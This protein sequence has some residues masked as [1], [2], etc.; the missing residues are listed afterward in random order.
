MR[1]KFN[2]IFC[3]LLLIMVTI[4]SGCSSTGQ[5]TQQDNSGGTSS[6]NGTTSSLPDVITLSSYDVGSI[7]YVQAATFGEVLK[8]TTGTTLRSIPAGNDVARM[9]PLMS[10]EV[11]FTLTGVGSILA[12]QGRYEF[13][14]E[15][16]GP[17]NIRTVWM[18]VGNQSQGINT[19]ADANIM[20]AYDLKGK[21]VAYV[22]GAP[23]LNLPMEAF[24]AFANLTWDDVKMVTFPSSAASYDGI[25]QGQVDAIYAG[26]TVPKLEELAASKRGYRIATL[27]HDDKEGWERLQKVA[28]WL[29]PLN[30]TLAAGGAATPENPVESASSPYPVL[31]ANA[32]KD[33]DLV[34]ELVKNI[35]TLYPQYSTQLEALEAWNIENLLRPFAV[36]YHEG[37]I[38]Y[39]K[40]INVW[41]EEDDQWNQ[42]L[43]NEYEATREAFDSFIEEN[44]GLSNEELAEKWEEVR[45]EVIESLQ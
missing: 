27:P 6:D 14:N 25:I 10:G 32:D 13:A 30:A 18:G 33:A 22:V 34:Y 36:P 20:T 43:I 3:V 45:N 21:R 11:D 26:S 1:T 42:L 39:L 44:K 31:V 38:R 35:H 17:Q 19:A 4:I 7:G 5:S 8:S 12:F 29:N 28:P 23:S 9:S 15:D 24:L 41:T 16:W 37:T 40:E 2:V